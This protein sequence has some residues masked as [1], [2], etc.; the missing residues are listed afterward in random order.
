ML[1]HLHQSLTKLAKV[2]VFFSPI[3]VL[4]VAVSQPAFAQCIPTNFPPNWLQA[5]E[6]AGGHTI[7]R[8]IGWSNQQLINRLI[9]SPQIA[10]ASTYTDLRNATTNIPVALSSHRHNLNNWAS[11]PNVPVGATRAVDYN[12]GRV[13]GRVAFRPSAL[14]NIRNSTNLRAVIRKS[15]RAGQCILLTSYPI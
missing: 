15:N 12:V 2:F 7:E 5:Q 11:N 3:S 14:K 8:H 10:K 6:Q 1:T 13:V 4:G 9:N